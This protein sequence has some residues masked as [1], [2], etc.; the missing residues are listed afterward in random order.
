MTQYQKKKF[1]S[2]EFFIY[3]YFC[4]VS[5]GWIINN[6]TYAYIYNHSP[7]LVIPYQGHGELEPIPA[8]TGWEEKNT[9]YSNA[10]K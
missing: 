7:P 5:Y 4:H 1:Y 2:H 8:V 3:E 9:I 6:D 10:Y